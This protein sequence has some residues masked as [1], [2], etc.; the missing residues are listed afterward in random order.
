MKKYY[1][2]KIILLAAVMLLAACNQASTATPAPPAA[3]AIPQTGPA[4]TP[5]SSKTG[6]PAPAPTQAGYPAP[7]DAGQ[8]GYPVPGS[9]VQVK[10]ADGTIKLIALSAVN[11]IAKVKVSV[12]GKELEL[13]KLGDL[14]KAAGIATYKSA[15][16]VGSNGPMQLSGDQL[17]K[18]YLDVAGDGMIKLVIDGVQPEK[19]ISAL[20]VVSV[21]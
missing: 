4:A 18:A 7:S 15:T 17:A 10:A 6:Y 2:L 21:E 19:W 16:V 8:A 12:N 14:L 3:T 1:G 11:A 9:G 13:R 5:A 20:T